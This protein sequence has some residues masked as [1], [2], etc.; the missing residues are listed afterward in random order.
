NTAPAQFR[1]VS[2]QRADDLFSVYAGARPGPM[3]RLIHCRSFSRHQWARPAGLQTAGPSPAMT[4]GRNR[5]LL[6]A[7]SDHA[8]HYSDNRFA[9]VQEARMPTHLL[10]LAA[11]IGP[12]RPFSGSIGV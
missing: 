9:S 1:L 4:G 8:L 7:P 5:L 6:L 2:A 11:P 12:R 10:G 3:L